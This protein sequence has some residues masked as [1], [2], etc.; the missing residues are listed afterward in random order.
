MDFFTLSF[1]RVYTNFTIKKRIIRQF[2]GQCHFLKKGY[3]AGGINA[4][5]VQMFPPSF[6]CI[7]RSVCGV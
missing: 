6:I 3:Q 4:K 1:L 5:K 2:G 7:L